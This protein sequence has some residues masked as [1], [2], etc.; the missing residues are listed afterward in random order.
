MSQLV[1]QFKD[2]L[3]QNIEDI[4]EDYVEIGIDSIMTNE[5][6]KEIPIVKTIFSGSKIVSTVYERNM[7]K[8]LYIFIKELNAGNIDE[9]KK[10]KYQDKINSNS[11][12]AEKELGR[13]LILLN[14][15]VDN[16]KAVILAKLFKSYIN[17][18]LSWNEFCEY[19]EIVNRMF[20]QDIVLLER[21][22][23]QNIDLMS[24][25]ADEFR[26]ERLYSLGLIG[27]TFKPL[28]YQNIKD[29][30]INNIRTISALGIKFC[31]CVFDGGK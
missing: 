24:N 27:I 13:I 12:I 22:R 4:G 1:P 9:N 16:E 11:Q 19:S 15:Y 8:N 2:S 23:N 20:I 31:E 3:F 18:I 7:I 14:Q 17:E 21:I 29:G 10:K 25:K 28:T 26:V 30:A 5:I 6:L